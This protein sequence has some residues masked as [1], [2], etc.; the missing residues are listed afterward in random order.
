MN[1]C[2]LYYSFGMVI[3]ANFLSLTRYL[4]ELVEMIPV[5]TLND[6][7]KDK[8]YKH[9]LIKRILS[10]GAVFIYTAWKCV[11]V[12]KWSVASQ[13]EVWQDF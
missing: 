13:E 11:T 2:W 1:V 7:N 6:H 12:K 3:T 5:W 4:E 10:V 9:Q 8:L